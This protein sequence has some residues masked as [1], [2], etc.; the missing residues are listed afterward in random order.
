MQSVQS[1]LEANVLDT[2]ARRARQIAS[3]LVTALAPGAE[4]TLVAEVKAL[5]SPELSDRFIRITRAD[6]SMLYR[7]GEPS[8]HSFIPAE[9]PPAPATFSQELRRK[10]SLPDGR[11]VLVAAVHAG[12][13]AGVHG[14]GGRVDRVNYRFVAPAPVAHGSRLA[15]HDRGRRE[16]R[17]FTR[18]AHAGAG[19]AHR[20]Q[21]RAH[22]ASQLWRSA[23]RW[24]AAAMSS[25]AWRF[26]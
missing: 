14:R 1:Y 21:G 7:S 12:G 6:G 23:C 13:G 11:G 16:W 4:S 3:T 25:S 10:Q 19:R 17:L 15:R 9:V 18:E 8:D 26:R 22:Y 5:Y 24:R 20:Q 2:Q